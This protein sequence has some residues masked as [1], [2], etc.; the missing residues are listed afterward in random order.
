VEVFVMDDGST[1]GTADWVRDRFPTVMVR[2]SETSRGPTH[3]RNAGARL[4]TAPYLFTI[5][6]DCLLAAPETLAQTV[7]LFDHPRVGAVTI[8]FIN[9]KSDNRLR[10]A[11]PHRDGVFAAYD[12]F[13]GMIAF[14]RD[15]FERVGGYRESYFMHVEESDLAVRM[16]AEG[17]IVRLGQADPIHHLESPSRDL[18]RLH[19]LGARNHVLF[20][21]YNVPWPYLPLHLAMSM[22]RTFVHGVRIGHP[23]LVSQGLLQGCLESVR[24]RR[25]RQPLSRATYRLSRR[26]KKNG[27]LILAEVEA[28]LKWSGRREPSP[29]KRPS[30]EI[31]TAVNRDIP[32]EGSHARQSVGL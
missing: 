29:A 11:A 25:D 10:S 32:T 16:L 12:Y 2:R 23:G 31:V 27:P 17:F 30:D 21:W 18:T 6:D 3:Q 5:D 22:A 28:C 20:C 7:A 24:R 26:L 1:D 14:R 8:P 19:R 13:G 4:A 15:L 9:V